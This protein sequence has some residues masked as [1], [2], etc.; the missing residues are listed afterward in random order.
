M[1]ITYALINA[2]VH[3][4][5]TYRSFASSTIG[6]IE[7]V[8]WVNTY[9]SGTIPT[10]SVNWRPTTAMADY[11]V[12]RMNDSHQATAPV[13]LKVVFGR[14]TAAGGNIYLR[15]QIGNAH[16]NS[17]SIAPSSSLRDVWSAPIR[18]TGSFEQMLV[19]G[20][21]NRLM[22]CISPDS[23]TALGTCFLLVQ[24]GNNRTGSV[25]PSYAH[26]VFFTSN[27]ST[28]TFLS[29]LGNVNNPILTTTV[30]ELNAA[31]QI[32]V[33]LPDDS[34]TDTTAA[35]YFG[36]NIA[37]AGMINPVL[38]ACYPLRD[39]VVIKRKYADDTND[40]VTLPIYNINTTYINIGTNY[41]LNGNM[42]AGESSVLVR[43]E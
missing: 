8:G 28:Q 9:A 11:A 2:Q 4:D 29:S 14:T 16:D 36:L 34:I 31:N 27:N 5:V 30:Y 25:D 43:W 41:P 12:F 7:A 18:N 6:V 13:F 22:F 42:A 33:F 3:N 20:D 26:A 35:T 21:T 23:N 37:P 40:V 38:P 32:P 17:G 19:S 10:A 15:A 1:P 24:R 39:L